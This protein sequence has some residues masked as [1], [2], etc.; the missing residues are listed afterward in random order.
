MERRPILDECAAQFRKY[1]ERE[2]FSL[3]DGLQSSYERMA[4]SPSMPF[5]RACKPEGARGKERE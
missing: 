4:F 3:F 5:P 1:S 2:R